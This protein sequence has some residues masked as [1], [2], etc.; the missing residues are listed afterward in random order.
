MEILNEEDM[1]KLDYE[2][3][4]EKVKKILS[5]IDVNDLELLLNSGVVIETQQLIDDEDVEYR[6]MDF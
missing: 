1:E 4:V 5:E 2:K 6:S 3:E